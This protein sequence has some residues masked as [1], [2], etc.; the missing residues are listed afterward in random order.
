MPADLAD[1]LLPGREAWLVERGIWSVLPPNAPPHPYDARAR[2]YD[3]LVGSAAYNRFFWGSSPGKYARFAQYAVEAGEGWHLEAGC[4]SLV[5]SAPAYAHRPGRPAVLLDHSLGML[6]RARQR[7]DVLAPRREAPVHLLQADLF[8][9]PF[10]DAAFDTVLSLGMLHLFARPEGMLAE[11]RR[12][13]APAGSCFVSSL[14]LGNRWGDRYL[15]FL[16]RAGEVAPPR[17][18]RE[19]ESLLHR[20]LER[21]LKLRQ[22]GNMLFVETGPWA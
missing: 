5:F 2:L 6:R 22:R 19:V 8:D 17:T 16:S 20:G 10:R 15:R 18:R 9:L 1:V 4:G 11:L 3:L 21:P 13:L 14:V 12:V 7:L